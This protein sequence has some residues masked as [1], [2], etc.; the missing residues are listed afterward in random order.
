MTGDA[1]VAMVDAA[2]R[3]ARGVE[4]LGTAALR[5]AAAFEK[6]VTLIEQE[7]ENDRG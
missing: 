4:R 3:G 5:I 7:I 2:Q 6:L 1:L